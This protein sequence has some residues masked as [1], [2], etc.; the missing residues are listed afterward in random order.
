MYEEQNNIYQMALS[1]LKPYIDDKIINEEEVDTFIQI[2][3][4]NIIFNMLNKTGNIK[5]NALYLNELIERKKKL[6]EI[7]KTRRC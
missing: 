7:K 5:M 1:K 3:E 4:K 2:I 6:E